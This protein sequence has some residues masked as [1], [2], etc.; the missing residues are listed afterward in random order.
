MQIF[1]IIL[2]I[3]SHLLCFRWSHHKI[4]VYT[5]QTDQEISRGDILNTRLAFTLQMQ[6]G[7]MCFQLPTD[8]LKRSITTGFCVMFRINWLETNFSHQQSCFFWRY[9]FGIKF[10][11]IQLY[12]YRAFHIVHYSKAALKEKIRKTEKYRKGKTQYSAWCL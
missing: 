3:I 9:Y 6:Y 11:S 5:W 7:Y 8:R 1:I 2:Y 4:S 10:N 12:S